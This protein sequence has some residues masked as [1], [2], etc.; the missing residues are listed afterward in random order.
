MRLPFHDQQSLVLEAQSLNIPAI[1][2]IFD[3]F[4]QADKNWPENQHYVML[5]KDLT[6]SLEEMGF[7]VL[8]L[9]P[10]YQTKMQA[11][12]WDRL[13]P[14]WVSMDPVDGHPNPEGHQFIADTL[15]EFINQHSELA[16][17]FEEN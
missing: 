8:D 3:A 7:Y 5:H 13:S 16:G 11:M 10:H 2:I 14:W 1:I 9:Y 17:I 4:I 15:V 12:N 6:V